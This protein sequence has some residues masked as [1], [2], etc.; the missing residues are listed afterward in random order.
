[1]IPFGSVSDVAPLLKMISETPTRTRPQMMPT[2]PSHMYGWMIRLL[3][4]T[5]NNAVKMITDPDQPEK[6]QIKSYTTRHFFGPALHKRLLTAH[7]VSSFEDACMHVWMDAGK[8]CICVFTQ[9]MNDSMHVCIYKWMS[10][11]LV[12]MSLGFLKFNF[13]SLNSY[14]KSNSEKQYQT[15]VCNTWATTEVTT[16]DYVSYIKGSTLNVLIH[17]YIHTYTSRLLQTRESQSIWFT[18]KV[19]IILRGCEWYTC[20]YACMYQYKHASL[21]TKLCYCLHHDSASPKPG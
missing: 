21:D 17:T 11:V 12:C 18:A 16:S 7:H 13:N 19:N 4:A 5:D 20:M 15:W 2:I 8:C 9:C 1:M 6:N 10:I 14:A 3:K